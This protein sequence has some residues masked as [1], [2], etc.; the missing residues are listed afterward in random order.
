MSTDQLLAG[1]SR[2]R[3]ATYKVSVD[4][5]GRVVLRHWVDSITIVVERP[6]SAPFVTFTK[7]VG[8]DIAIKVTTPAGEF[9]NRLTI[10]DATLCWATLER[11]D[12][13]PAGRDADHLIVR[14]GKI[15]RQP[16]SRG[17]DA[18]AGGSDARSFAGDARAHARTRAAARTP[19][20]APAHPPARNH[21]ARTGSGPVPVAGATGDTHRTPGRPRTPGGPEAPG[22]APARRL[23]RLRLA[24]ARAL[25]RHGHR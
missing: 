24:L 12:R 23:D 9:R 19:A 2:T 25:R 8:K 4:A 14:D 7:F 22:R 17:S 18:R 16:R 3:P 11:F 21:K 5:D 20:R 6:D 13:A 1:I 10:P 15:L